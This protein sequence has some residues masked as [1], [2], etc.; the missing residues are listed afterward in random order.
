MARSDTVYDINCPAA[1][2]TRAAALLLACILSVP[3]FLILSLIN[4]LF[5]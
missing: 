3:V 5:H 4:W 2:P 1:R